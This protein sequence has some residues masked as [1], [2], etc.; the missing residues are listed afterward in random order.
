M[1]FDRVDTWNSSAKFDQAALGA[2]QVGNERG[3]QIDDQYVA[4]AAQTFDELEL[5]R[6]AGALVSYEKFSDI[7]RASEQFTGTRIREAIDRV[8]GILPAQGLEHRRN[9]TGRGLR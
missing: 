2:Q 4:A 7:R 8:I 3:S 5:G 6:P 9:F 1:F